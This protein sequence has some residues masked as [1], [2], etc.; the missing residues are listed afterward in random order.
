V[1]DPSASTGSYLA[2]AYWQ[3]G[4][5]EQAC[6]LWEGF[7][8]TKEVALARHYTVMCQREN[9]LA[10]LEEWK[11]RWARGDAELFIL[12]DI[13]A[14]YADLGEKV[15][16][17]DWLGKAYQARLGLLVYVKIDPGFYS[18]HGEARFQMLLE[19]MGFPE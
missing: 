10:V 4:M 19:R 17:L 15:Q 6:R 12:W 1:L 3:T 8:W 16:A 18:L 7:G 11:A 5:Y 9:A 2:M 14:I 13:A